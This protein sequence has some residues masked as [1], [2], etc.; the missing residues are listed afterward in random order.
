VNNLK[1]IFAF[2]IFF[3]FVIIYNDQILIFGKEIFNRLLI[4]QEQNF[5]IF[6]FLLLIVNFIYFLSPI[7]TFPIIIFNGFILKNMGFI[8]SY[9]IIIVCSLILFKSI[10]RFKFILNNNF[11][12]KILEK[13]N[14]NKNND[15][16][17]FVIASSRY[18][19][20]YFVHNIFFGS[21]LKN[22]KIFFIAIL[23]GEIPIIFILNQF[24]SQLRDLSD[25]TSINLSDI[26]KIEYLLTLICFFLFLTIINRST[27][28]I[29][30]KLK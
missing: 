13:I 29:K 22:I 21:I 4:Y 24:G 1:Y 16:N 20:P 8:L 6:L 12:L 10:K 5:I 3:I 19:L 9:I 25:L 27:K 17:F 30:K 26:L 23:I 7:P 14:N 2:I 18:V 15:V 11:F 28:Y